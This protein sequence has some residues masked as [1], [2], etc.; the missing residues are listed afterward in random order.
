M[1]V[2]VA[3]SGST[4]MCEAVR[5]KNKIS[6][7]KVRQKCHRVLVGNTKSAEMIKTMHSLL[8]KLCIVLIVSLDCVFL[9]R[10]R[11]HFLGLKSDEKAS[12]WT[13]TFAGVRAL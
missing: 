4:E 1:Y 11:W 9:T 2:Q 3:R 6:D 7:K 12:N 8:A 13:K 10:T 5:I